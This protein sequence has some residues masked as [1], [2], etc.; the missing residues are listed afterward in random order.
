MPFKDPLAKKDYDKKYQKSSEYKT[1]QR[2]YRKKNY[3]TSSMGEK[4]HG[5]V[6]SGE[7]YS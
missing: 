7:R 4:Q 1:Y 2:T 5:Y 3:Y 6:C